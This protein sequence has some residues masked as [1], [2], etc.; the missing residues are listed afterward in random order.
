MYPNNPIQL[1]KLAYTRQEEILRE[2]P[3]RHVY[4]LTAHEGFSLQRLKLKRWI[5]VGMVLALVWLAS[6]ITGARSV[7]ED[8]YS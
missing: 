4:E 5:P 2:L 8:G 1:E 3:N 6:V 7:S